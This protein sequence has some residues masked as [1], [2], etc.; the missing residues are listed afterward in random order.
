[1]DKRVIF[2]VAGSGKTTLI[3]NNLN[4]ESNFL[5]V[6]Y[7]NNNVHN[8]R[9]GILKKFGYFPDNI[10]LYSY[11]S[12]LYG[13]CYRPFLHSELGTKGI[14]YE[15]NPFKFAKKNERKYFIDKFNRLYSSR[16]AKLII[17]QDVV[18]EVIARISKYY[19]YLYIDEIQD[20]AGNDFN[21]LKEI[22][23]ANLNQLYV[24][25][26]FQH[27]FDTSRD[28]N[29]N[30]GLH[31]NF[32]TYKK[33]F[34]N[35]GLKLDLETL[36]KSY[37]CSSTVCKFISDN[38]KINI[39]SHRADTT[40]IK[41]IAKKEE[42]FTIFS[43]PNIVKLFYRE[44][45][46][47]N[48]FSRNWGDSKGENKYFDVCTVVNKTT[49]EHLEKNKLDQLAPTTKNKLYVA[50]SRTRNNLYLIPDTLLK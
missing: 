26:F 38:L 42:A 13:F 12:F 47:F 50:L 16:I 37:R 8:L 7:T 29:I 1:M 40:E 44:H 15:Q 11:Y 5:L 39:E 9:T 31:D 45:Y 19:D 17:E 30:S 27:T 35:M 34:E 48:C 28:G 21:L 20:F 36:S 41:L 2:A 14:N 46:K 3:I 43:N 18:K 23:K 22:S 6:T 49:M 24:G 4:L 33:A 25:D 32:E 10:K